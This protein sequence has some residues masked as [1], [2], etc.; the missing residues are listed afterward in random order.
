MSSFGALKQQKY[1]IANNPG[2]ATNWFASNGLKVISPNGYRLGVKNIGGTTYTYG[3]QSTTSGTA[4]FRPF[5]I[6]Y[7]PVDGSMSYYKVFSDQPFVGPPYTQIV[8]FE[9]D[10]AG[11]K[12]FLTDARLSSFKLFKYD[13]NDVF[14]L[15]YTLTET[16]EIGGSAGMIKD[17]SDNLYILSYTSTYFIVTKIDPTTYTV[18]WSKQVTTSITEGSIRI[19]N[20]NGIYVQTWFN[21]GVT[22]TLIKFDTSGNI[23]WQKTLSGFTAGSVANAIDFDSSNNIYILNAGLSAGSSVLVAKL[24]SSG[25]VLFGKSVPGLGTSAG[26]WRSLVVNDQNNIVLVHDMPAGANA[27]TFTF[28][29]DSSGTILNSV[30][31]GG[32]ISQPQAYYNIWVKGTNHIYSTAAPLSASNI[33]IFTIKLPNNNDTAYSQAYSFSITDSGGTTTSF[34]GTLI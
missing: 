21:T 32:S 30:R 28:T 33:P 6:G 13:S 23:T 31:I 3:R 18:I 22:N 12:H 11:N 14:S 16:T 10:S 7:S 5:V 20:N 1:S 25:N 29:I 17:S 19:D 26:T 4:I 9:I 34:S 2:F 15:G 27:Y 8:A 24:D